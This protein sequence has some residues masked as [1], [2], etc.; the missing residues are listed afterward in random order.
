MILQKLAYHLKSFLFYLSISC[1]SLYWPLSSSA[2]QTQKAKKKFDYLYKTIEHGQDLQIKLLG[3][4]DN[5]RLNIRISPD[6]PNI[7]VLHLVSSVCKTCVLAYEPG[8]KVNEDAL[9]FTSTSV[10]VKRPT[11]IPI[12]DPVIVDIAIRANTKVAVSINGNSRLALNTVVSQPLGFQAQSSWG[13]GVSNRNKFFALA[14]T[15]FTVEQYEREKTSLKRNK[16]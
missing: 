14:M 8:E 13:K 12:E 2:Q 7:S 1:L 15:R 5:D 6:A 4:K 16:Q 9:S 10:E 11:D 3:F